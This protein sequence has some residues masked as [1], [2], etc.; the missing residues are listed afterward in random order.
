MKIRALRMSDVGRFHAP[1]ALE[2]LTGK[3]DVL[4]GPN[5]L[6]KSTIFRAIEAVF[7]EKHTVG[8]KVLEALRPYSGGEP[9]I[10]ADF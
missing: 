7:L 2:G 10:E 6:G 1:V 8:G 4:A 5:E 9:L 3:L